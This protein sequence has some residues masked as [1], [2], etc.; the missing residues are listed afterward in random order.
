MIVRKLELS[1]GAAPFR[2]DIRMMKKRARPRSASGRM[3]PNAL[4]ADFLRRAAQL[5]RFGS[6][7]LAIAEGRQRRHRLA[8]RDREID[9]NDLAVGRA[10]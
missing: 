4:S 6:Q 2:R 5:E 1:R 3:T 8:W 10:D 9:G 7:Q